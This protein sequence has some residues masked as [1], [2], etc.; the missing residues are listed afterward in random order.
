VGYHSQVPQSSSVDEIR[1]EFLLV[2]LFISRQ[3]YR[4][5][6]KVIDSHPQTGKAA[7]TLSDDFTGVDQAAG[8]QYLHLISTLAGFVVHEFSESQQTALKAETFAIS[9]FRDDSIIIPH[10][11]SEEQLTGG[12]EQAVLANGSSWGWLAS[13]APNV[14][15]LGILQ[16]LQPSAVARLVCLSCSSVVS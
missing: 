5:A 2:S 7:L 4:R 9:L 8:H 13:E 3:L 16:A 6:T 11:S 10:N 14:L 15:S 1:R 12:V